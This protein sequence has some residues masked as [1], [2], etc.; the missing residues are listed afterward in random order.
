MKAL[1]RGEVKWRML[2]MLVLVHRSL[3]PRVAGLKTL[4]LRNSRSAAR[5]SH[6]ALFFSD[7]KRATKCVPK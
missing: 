2:L 4:Q 5:L 7:Q 3:N 1:G 6:L